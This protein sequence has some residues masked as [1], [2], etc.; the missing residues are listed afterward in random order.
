MIT[1]RDL[2][3]A[4][5]VLTYSPLVH[6]CAR[7][8]AYIDE[9]GPIR[10]T[11]TKAFNTTFVAW[12]NDEFRW[13]SRKA[14]L[15]LSCRKLNHEGD[16]LPVAT[17]HHVMRDL[18]LGVD[19]RG[20]FRL[21]ERGR[22]FARHP[23]KSAGELLAHFLFELRLRDQLRYS[24]AVDLHDWRRV[25]RVL[26]ILT[27]D[28]A[29]C[30]DL[31]EA[32]FGSKTCAGANFA[33]LADLFHHF[34]IPLTCAGLLKEVRLASSEQGGLLAEAVFIKTPLWNAV[35]DLGP[36]ASAQLVTRH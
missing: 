16:H 9:H 24:D 14:I 3:T 32:I 6:A 29:S 2:N 17:V 10:L 19:D 27:E 22:F 7:T 12:A 1:F 34:L 31:G 28:G 20:Y 11:R 21:T 4:E 5:P 23:E 8:C 33:I 13:P 26:H 15:G 35:V 36:V 18:D 30:A 25:F